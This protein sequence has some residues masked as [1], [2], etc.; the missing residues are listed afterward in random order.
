MS[1]EITVMRRINIKQYA[2]NIITNTLIPLVKQ[3]KGNRP[4]REPGRR[5]T[6]NFRR[7]SKDAEYISIIRRDRFSAHVHANE[8]KK[9]KAR[10]TTT[11]TRSERSTRLLLPLP[12][13]R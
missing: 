7:I 13:H 8:P 5:H 11:N 10:N 2:H 12:K 6:F 3:Q 9:L 1:L 4:F